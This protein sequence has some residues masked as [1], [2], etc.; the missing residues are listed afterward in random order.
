MV[1]LANKGSV[2]ALEVYGR[3]FGGR[4]V[5]LDDFGKYAVSDSG[6]I[7]SSRQ[8]SGSPCKGLSRDK[9]GY[10][11]FVLRCVY[12]DDVFFE[13]FVSSVHRLVWIG[14]NGGIP[15]GFEVSHLDGDKSN[16]ALVN[17]ELVTR[18][19]NR[20]HA[21]ES[22][23]MA[24]GV[25]NELKVEAVSALLGLGWLIKDVAGAFGVSPEA[26]GMYIKK[27]GLGDE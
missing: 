10:H 19:Q 15:D 26:M 6:L 17:L 21:K 25:R 11:P 18:K 16:N 5:Y 1:S 24:R 9:K 14:F 8:L 20:V 2:Q 4:W 12:L 3:L 13:K 27:H 22:G 23:L 7:R